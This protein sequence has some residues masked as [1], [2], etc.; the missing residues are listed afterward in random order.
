MME[1]NV[2]DCSSEKQCT[3]RADNCANSCSHTE[4]SSHNTNSRFSVNQSNNNINSSPL[5][6]PLEY[7]IVNFKWKKVSYYAN[8]CLNINQDNNINSPLARSMRADYNTWKPFL[9]L[10][11]GADNEEAGRLS[12]WDNRI[13][14]KLG[15]KTCSGYFSCGKHFR[16]P[17]AAE[18]GLSSTCTACKQRDDWFGCIQCSGEVDE[19]IAADVSQR[20]YDMNSSPISSAR[21][22]TQ[23]VG[24]QSANS[25][26][27][28]QIRHNIIC[29]NPKQRHG[30]EQN[31]YW[32]YLAAFGGMLKVGCSYERRFFE[33]MIEQ[34]ADFGC[35]LG[36]IQD[37]GYARLLE[38]KIAR[39]LGLPD[40]ID[41]SM[42]QAKMF[43]DPNSSVVSIAS[44]IA[45]LI[46]GNLI[47]LR[48]ETFDFRQYYRLDNVVIRPRPVQVMPGMRFIGDVLATKGNIIVMRTAAGTISL[49][50][51]RLVGYNAE[52]HI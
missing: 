48:P 16:C 42:K 44:A 43:G 29:K 21:Y 7:Q 25:S 12:L 30:C 2:T 23:I 28:V 50:A 11:N 9:M 49:D 37:G 36:I 18:V 5:R 47:D 24:E 4:Q 26:S 41:G 14:I 51:R 1:M 33:R 3:E 10:S 39:Y 52:I 32:I 46:D 35:R 27:T 45:K 38:Q 6:S 17:D 22:D 31:K 8:S 15:A 40:K 20:S 19:R 13:S 34:G